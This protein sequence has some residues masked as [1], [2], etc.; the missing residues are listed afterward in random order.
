MKRPAIVA[1]DDLEYTEHQGLVPADHTLTLIVREGNESVSVELDLTDDNRQV[2]YKDVQRWLDAGTP[3]PPVRVQTPRAKSRAYYKEL[4]A[5][6]DKRGIN[7]RSKEGNYYYSNHLVRMF[8]EHEN[9]PPGELFLTVS[10]EPDRN[11]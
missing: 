1:Y 4:R 5:F 6:A 9:G 3:P 2:F 10:C 8:A 11:R 7:Y